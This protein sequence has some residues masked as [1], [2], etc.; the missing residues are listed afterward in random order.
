MLITRNRLITAI[1]FFII[2]AILLYIILYWND[3]R[4]KY[5]LYRIART[6]SEQTARHN[7]EKIRNVG[8]SVIPLLWKHFTGDARSVR[9]G[10]YS[11][12][13]YFI[14]A[15]CILN[16]SEKE[17]LETKKQ[18]ADIYIPELLETPAA[19]ERLI[20]ILINPDFDFNFRTI[21]WEGFN[22]ARYGFP[23][24]AQGI[25]PA[26]YLRSENEKIRAFWLLIER[27]LDP[28]AFAQARDEAENRKSAIISEVLGY[29]RKN[30][31]RKPSDPV[32]DAGVKALREYMGDPSRLYYWDY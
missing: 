16:A 3:I 29:T 4:V 31:P 14:E 27:D 11:F 10:E 24:Y 1:T 28:P 5:Y 2:F 12:K 13:L 22:S 21:L 19:Q 17:S 30:G 25:D 7:M 23:E 8:P 26:D 18:L 15:A 9:F 32:F 20:A 6:E